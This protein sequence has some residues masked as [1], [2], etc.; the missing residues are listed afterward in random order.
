MMVD[1]ITAPRAISINQGG[2]RMGLVYHRICQDC[3]NEFKTTSSA[4]SICLHCK[5]ISD[6]SA[7][8]GAE[9]F[10]SDGGSIKWK[11]GETTVAREKRTG[12]V[13]FQGNGSLGLG[14]MVD[15]RVDPAIQKKPYRRFISQNRTCYTCKQ[16]FTA[17]QFHQRQ[18]D[19][20]LKLDR[21][22]EVKMARNLAEKSC[23]RC[24]KPFH[25]KGNHSLYCQE[26]VC[27]SAHNKN[28]PKTK[29]DQGPAGFQRHTAVVEVPDKI[30]G[31]LVAAPA[32]T[33]VY[34]PNTDRVKLM[35]AAKR[36]VA[37]EHCTVH[38]TITD[39]T[40]WTFQE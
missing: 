13:L 2:M 29:P 26:C 5:A 31:P 20:C 7:M 4:E 28:K 37:S 38:I 8:I 23:A 19:E 22:A 1:A 32:S 34:I 33:P 9:E 10:I 11:P 15:G 36:L 12:S 6:S 27:D 17:V 3:G 18:C 40:D 16:K 30:P 14:G 35:D 24:G 21:N 39:K 25:P